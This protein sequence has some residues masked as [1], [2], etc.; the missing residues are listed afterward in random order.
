MHLIWRINY[1]KK[2]YSSEKRKRFLVKLVTHFRLAIH[3]SNY[4]L[5]ITDYCNL[6]FLNLE[7]QSPLNWIFNTAWTLDN[8]KRLFNETLF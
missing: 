5:P 4:Y 8:F 2:R 7:I 3:R 1:E 6:R